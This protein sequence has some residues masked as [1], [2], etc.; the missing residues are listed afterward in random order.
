MEKAFYPRQEKIAI[1][2]LLPKTSDDKIDESLDILLKS[3]VIDGTEIRGTGNTKGHNYR[4]KMAIESGVKSIAVVPDRF[5]DIKGNGYTIDQNRKVSVSSLPTYENYK[6]AVIYRINNSTA[7]ASPRAK[8]IFDNDKEQNLEDLVKKLGG[9][10]AISDLEVKVPDTDEN[11]I[12]V[13]NNPDYTKYSNPYVLKNITIATINGKRYLCGNESA[14]EQFNLLYQDL[15]KVITGDTTTDLSYPVG[16]GT[17]D[18]ILATNFQY[19]INEL[20]N[21]GKNGLFLLNDACNLHQDK[22]ALPTIDK[23]TSQFVMNS[24]NVY[25]LSNLTVRVPDT[26]ENSVRWGHISSSEVD[27]TKYK[28]YAL[29]DV[30]FSNSTSMLYNNA[31]AKR[32]WESDATYVL[33]ISDTGMRILYR[34]LTP[35]M[36]DEGAIL[37]LDSDTN[38]PISRTGGI[39]P[40]SDSTV[41]YMQNRATATLVS[42]LGDIIKGENSETLDISYGTYLAIV[43]DNNDNYYGLIGAAGYPEYSEDNEI[44]WYKPKTN[45]DTSQFKGLDMWLRFESINEMVYFLITK[46]ENDIVKIA[47]VTL[48]AG[49]SDWAVNKEVTTLQEQTDY[50]AKNTE[51]KLWAYVNPRTMKPYADDYWFHQGEPYYVKSITIAPKNKTIK[52]NRLVVRADQ[53]PGMYMVVGETYI[54]DRDTGKDERMQLKFPLCK[55][56]SDH[57]FTLDAEGDPTTFNLDLEVA[58]PAN[59]VMMEITAYEIAQKMVEGENGCYYAIDGS[60]E[61][62]S[63]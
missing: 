49:V 20:R 18:I 14:L 8:I 63:E 27:Y 21:N 57:T 30:L 38:L 45:V 53:W 24:N 12:W 60:T 26:Q 41:T 43:V 29:T 11:S 36:K 16:S 15:M 46:Y 32:Q 25:T 5:Y 31:W 28:T 61:V 10:I 23:A 2:N 19:L 59:G 22:K 44:T 48:D 9:T 33:T 34:A 50:E 62:L 52:G 1:S 3:S 42:S 51:G 39:D 6:D 56:K 40:S 54:R 35:F 47:P 17:P 7:G 55:V 58:R 13:S 4:W 37:T